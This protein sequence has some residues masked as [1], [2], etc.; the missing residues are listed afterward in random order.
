M[1]DNPQERGAGVWV[2]EGGET[3]LIYRLRRE[4]VRAWS[5][6]FHEKSTHDLLASAP[7]AVG[8]KI[9][10]KELFALFQNATGTGTMHTLLSD[11]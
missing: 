1:C 8:V 3:V 6:P 4:H 10:R 5:W 2:Q 7:R 11:A 9:V